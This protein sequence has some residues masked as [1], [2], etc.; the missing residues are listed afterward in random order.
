MKL[1]TEEEE[2]VT[3]EFKPEEVEWDY[4]DEYYTIQSIMWR[5]GCH[6]TPPHYDGG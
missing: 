1:L 4:S 6:R 2:D 5:N 3:M